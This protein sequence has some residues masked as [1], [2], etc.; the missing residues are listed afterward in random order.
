MHARAQNLHVTWGECL[1][2]LSRLHLYFITLVCF[3]SEFGTNPRSLC[4]PRSSGFCSSTSPYPYGRITLLHRNSRKS[5]GVVVIV[6]WY[7]YVV[8]W[9][10][11]TWTLWGNYT[12]TWKWNTWTL[13]GNY[14]LT[15]LSSNFPRLIFE[16]LI[17]VGAF[18]IGICPCCLG[19]E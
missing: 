15:D 18:A 13:W 19:D 11:N 9:K 6:I 5:Y 8:T 17:L 4:T 3:L 1:L 7:S 10:W 12:L 2:Q 14:T 16:K